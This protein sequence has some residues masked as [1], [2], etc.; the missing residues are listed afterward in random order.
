MR[1]DPSSIN[2]WLPAFFPPRRCPTL[3]QHF[4]RKGEEIGVQLSRKCSPTNKYKVHVF[5]AA[6]RV[7]PCRDKLITTVS[8]FCLCNQP[9]HPQTFPPLPLMEPPPTDPPTSSSSSLMRGCD[10]GT[11]QTH[12]TDQKSCDKTETRRGPSADTRHQNS[13][14]GSRSLPVFSAA[15]HKSLTWLRKKRQWREA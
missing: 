3:A 8:V 7:G 6:S 4:F 14:P 12:P 5:D 11:E 15:P 1:L 13:T 9:S 2:R 10:G